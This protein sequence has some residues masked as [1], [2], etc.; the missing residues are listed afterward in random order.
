MRALPWRQRGGGHRHAQSH[1]LGLRGLLPGA[2][3]VCIAA[4]RSLADTETIMAGE[5][6]SSRTREI[7]WGRRRPRA[8]ALTRTSRPARIG[9]GSETACLLPV[10][11]LGWWPP[12]AI[13]SVPM[14]RAS[15]HSRRGAGKYGGPRTRLIRVGRYG[16]GRR[17]AEPGNLAPSNSA[18]PTSP[19]VPSPS[20]TPFGEK[21]IA[22]VRGTQSQRNRDLDRT[23]QTLLGIEDVGEAEGRPRRFRRWGQCP[24]PALRCLPMVGSLRPGGAEL[25][26]CASCSSVA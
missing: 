9:T 24:L 18:S 4:H 20:S 14:R 1:H 23:L 19:S 13:A 2:P 5:H 22:P 26:F 21:L 6:G 3:A 16:H 25:P 8:S 15:M 7:S 11:F 12:A 10:F 17:Q